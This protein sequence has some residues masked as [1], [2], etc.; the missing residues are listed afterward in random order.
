MPLTSGTKLGPY[1]I[2][3][4]LGVGGMG[5]VYR[6]RDTRLER[7]VAVKVLPESLAHDPER[8]RRFE[9]EA[10]AVAALSH[11]N[12]LAIFDVGTH[13]SVAYLVSELLEGESLR[14]RL[15]AGP[16]AARKSIEYASQIADG[17]AAA[18]DKGI[19]H[20][21]LKPE[22]VF[23]TQNGRVKIIDFGLAK[24]ERPDS[25]ATA[26]AVA[27][28]QLNTAA[29]VVMG[30]AAY[31]SPEQVRGQIVDSRSDLFSFGAILFEMLT[32]NRPFSGQSSIETMNAIL[33]ED[34]PEIDTTRLKVS[35]GLERIVRHCLEK[36]PADRFQ[37]ARDLAFA[38]SAIS[39]SQAIS[40]VQTAIPRRRSWLPWAVA[41]LLGM[42][43]LAVLLLFRGGQTARIERMEFAIPM[44]EEVSNLALSLDGRM[45]AFVARDEVSGS[46]TLYVQRIGSSQA[47]ALP[48]TDGATYPFWSPDGAY[49]AFFADGKLKKIAASGGAAQVLTTT[50]SG[51]GGTWGSRGVIVYAP[52]AGG[53]LWRINADGSNAAALTEKK[54]IQGEASHRW[55]VFLPDGE[56]FLF[57]AGQFSNASEDR[58]S[59]IY[60]S[61]LGGGE[62][63]FVMHT[64]SNAIYSNGYLFYV[65]DQHALTAV[66]L[67]ISKFQ[68]TGEPRVVGDGV[69][70]QPS[71]YWGSF[72]VAQN[73][74]AVY[75]TASGAAL[76]AFTWFDRTG[77]DLGRVGEIGCLANPAIS[78]D[79]QRV[80][81]DVTDVKANNIDVWIT[82][83]QKGTSWRFTFDPAEEVA[84]NWSRDGSTIAFRSATGG[85]TLYTKKLHGLEAPKT[86]SQ[87]YGKDD[88]I[89]NSWSG[90]NQKIL[91][92]LQSASGGSDLVLIP[93]AGGKGEPFL[94]TKASENNG[95]ISPD[96]KWVAYASNESGDWEIY[97]TSFPRAA[98][99]WQISRGGGTEPRWRSDGKEVFYIG[100]GGMLMSASVNTQE[101]FSS[102][103]PASLFKLRSRAPISSTD[104]FSYDVA[105]DGN[106]FLV[107]RYVKPDHIAPLTIMLNATADL[108]K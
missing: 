4:S 80:A 17:L 48:G 16:V 24:V 104:M 12:V 101:G 55:P 19:I 5:E 66:P 10:R 92:T 8:M 30:T 73:G 15:K 54:F 62:K 37:S 14:E 105:K 108:R 50:S 67:D 102:G 68:I 94:A 18:H 23:L 29:G 26:T 91:C 63:T 100:P 61:S 43:L 25:G 1:E 60:F 45:L 20:R 7:D 78:P 33:K 40:A 65:A 106:R 49:V 89:P 59:G 42:L 41:G 36:N 82:E 64:R 85:A 103:T 22:N 75:S 99:K 52:D 51:R 72:A 93:A 31:M 71:T 6:A 107:N 47:T 98:G 34:P 88:I 95:M 77:K 38:L 97:V 3:S 57:W 21:D 70:F 39:G 56:H 87:E 81:V 76:S 32:G 53:A 2:V 58:T 35:P 86:L 27:S 90:D 44:K 96:N 28:A 79:G 13:N 69:T 9:Q 84:G 74:T 83:L 11:P 46:N